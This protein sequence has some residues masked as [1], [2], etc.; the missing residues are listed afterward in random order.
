M[1]SSV[2]VSL[3][4]VGC[5]GSDLDPG[6]GDDPGT[7]TSTLAIQGE[8]SAKPRIVNARNPGDFDTQLSV[9]VVLDGQPVTTGTVTVTTRNASTPLV[10]HADPA[11]WEGLATGYDEV[12]VLDVESGQHAVQGVRVDGP[13]IHVF[14]QPLAGATVDSTMPLPV[15]WDKDQVADSIWIDSGEIDRLAIA[16][17]GSYMLA[18][19]SLKADKE[20]ARENTIEIMRSNRVSPA[21]AVA[22]S[23]VD[24]SVTNRIQVIAQ[25]NPLL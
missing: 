13:D 12:Y 4:L 11:R 1:K 17:T 3:I 20:T 18:G 8:M 24:V 21:G 10:F 9:R 22:G 14:T 19:G 6:A 2:V 16:D 25:P 23:E 7:G 15:A 5:G